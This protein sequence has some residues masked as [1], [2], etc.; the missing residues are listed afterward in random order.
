[1]PTTDVIEYK[2]PCCGGIVE[3]DSGSQLMKCPYCDTTFDPEALK[4]KDEALNQQAPDEMEWQQSGETWTEEEADRMDV[5]SCKSCGGEIIVPENTGATHCPFCGNPVVLTSRFSGAL[6]PDYVLPFQV[7]K[8]QAR[9]I[10]MRSRASMSPSG[11]SA[12]MP[13]RTSI[14]TQPRRGSGEAEIPNIRKP[15]ISVCREPAASASTICR[16][17]APRRWTIR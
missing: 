17:T 6:K 4:Q 7:S 14:I 10:W 2:C 12:R 9:A 16:W 1:M 11:C 8:E 3:F 13:T 5:Y 15:L